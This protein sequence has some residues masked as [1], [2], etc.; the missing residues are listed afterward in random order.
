MFKTGVE[1]SRVEISG[2]EI[3]RGWN[4]PDGIFGSPI[5]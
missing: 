3:S 2:G 5:E 1:F 4:I